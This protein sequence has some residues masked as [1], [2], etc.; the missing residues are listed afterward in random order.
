[1]FDPYPLHDPYESQANPVGLTQI[2]TSDLLT[3]KLEFIRWI[4][5]KG[6]AISAKIELILLEQ[7]AFRREDARL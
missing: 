6:L 4:E 3:L 5:N 1:M 7:E 2:T